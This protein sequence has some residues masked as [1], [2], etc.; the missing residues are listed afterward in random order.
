MKE[1]D[2]AILDFGAAVQIDPPNENDRARLR[3]VLF[4]SGRYPKALEGKLFDI[5]KIS[6]LLS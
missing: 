1:W 6:N 2:S 3:K 4:E 5:N